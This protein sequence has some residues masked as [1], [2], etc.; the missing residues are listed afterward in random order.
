MGFGKRK[1]EKGISKQLHRPEN[2]YALEDDNYNDIDTVNVALQYT[3]I[4]QLKNRRTTFTIY[5]P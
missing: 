4:L 5:S 1:Q 2:M 3:P